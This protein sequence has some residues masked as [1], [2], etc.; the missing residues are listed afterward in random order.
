MAKMT[1]CSKIFAS[2]AVLNYSDTN[3]YWEKF[4]FKMKLDTEL[5][6]STPVDQI[7]GSVWDSVWVPEFNMKHLK[8]AKGHIG[9][10]AL[11][12]TVKI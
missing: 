11:S 2:T 7:K 1:H 8:K 6:Q 12:I 4:N 9:Q 3:D 10:D 5:E